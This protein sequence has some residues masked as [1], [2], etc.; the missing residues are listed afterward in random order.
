MRIADRQLVDQIVRVLT[1]DQRRRAIRRLPGLQ[2]QRIAG[3]AHQWVERDHGVQ[4][5][6]ASAER[7]ARHAHQHGFEEGLALPPRARPG[8]RKPVSRPHAASGSTPRA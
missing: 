6:L 7:S 3:F 8:R 1:V 2:Q 5:K 4:A